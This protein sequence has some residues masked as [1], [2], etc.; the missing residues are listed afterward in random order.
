MAMKITR[1]SDPRFV[2]HLYKDGTYHLHS[3]QN[4][5]TRNRKENVHK[6]ASLAEVAKFIRIGE[7]CL[8]MSIPGSNR[9]ANLIKPEDIL[10]A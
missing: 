4:A 8:R 9:T 2:P 1:K 5:A 3:R 7:H 6:A 10:I